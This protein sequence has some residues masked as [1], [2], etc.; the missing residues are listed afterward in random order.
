MVRHY[1]SSTGSQG[2]QIHENSLSRVRGKLK[3]QHA[4]VRNVLPLLG[5]TVLW[6]RHANNVSTDSKDLF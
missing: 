1:W 5:Q 4:G 6:V 2:K 3:H